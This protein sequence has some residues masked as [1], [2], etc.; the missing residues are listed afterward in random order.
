MPT[1]PPSSPST[2][3]GARFTVASRLP[4]PLMPTSAR[5]NAASRSVT[6]RPISTVI[7]WPSSWNRSS[8]GTPRRNTEQEERLPSGLWCYVPP[9]EAPEV[10]PLP[11]LEAGRIT[12]GSLHNLAKLNDAVFDLWA[13]VLHGLPSARLLLVRDALTP[14]R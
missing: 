7:P 2:S 14:A 9:D 13:R 6:C 3:A 4:S 11:A 5:P 12:F 1:P 8:L 10:G